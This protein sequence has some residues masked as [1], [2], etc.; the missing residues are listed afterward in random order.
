MSDHFL[1]LGAYPKQCRY[2]MTWINDREFVTAGEHYGR[3]RKEENGIFMY[4]VIS[5]EWKL[6]IKYPKDFITTT[7]SI[8]Y[9]KNTKMLYLYGDESNMV[10][11]NIDTKEFKIVKENAKY[12]GERPVLVMINNQCHVI[13]GSDSKDHLVW[14][15]NK[16]E[17]ETMFTFPHWG[18]GNSGHAVVYAEKS[19]VLYLLG[20]Y[21]YGGTGY[22][23]SIWKCELDC[24]ETSWVCLKLKLPLVFNYNAYVL[25]PDETYIVLFFPTF[26]YLFDLDQEQLFKVLIKGMYAENAMLCGDKNDELLVCGYIKYVCNIMHILMPNELIMLFEQYYSS[27]IVYLSNEN[28]YK[29]DLKYILNAERVLIK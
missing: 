24:I 8:C 29:V 7:H 20:G 17:F 15:D 28:H 19:N 12:T 13:G 21:D 16:C 18:K 6:L 10:N 1:L 23:Y 11:I 14:N 2:N 22:N 27:E 9:N 3:N 5:N 25:T 4:N 26:I